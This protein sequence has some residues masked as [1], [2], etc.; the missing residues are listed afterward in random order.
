MSC[1][2]NKPLQIKQFY[3]YTY[4]SAQIL[5][6]KE[7]FFLV[8]NYRNDSASSRYIDSFVFVKSK[9]LKRYNSYSMCFLKE[10]KYTNWEKIKK[11]P[12]II[13]PYSQNQN[14]NSV[15]HD[16]IFEYYWVDGEFNFKE[17]YKNGEPEL[18]E[19][20]ESNLK[21]TIEMLPDTVR[22]N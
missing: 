2:S 17:K 11:N 12:K 6:E 4:D 14:L 15:L 19:P 18:I 13:D 21:F 20:K 22:K 7:D 10:S 16:I 8:E 3:P 1:T 5:K 9:S